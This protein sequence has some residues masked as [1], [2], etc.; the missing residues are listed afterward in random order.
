MKDKKVLQ[1]EGASLKLDQMPHNTLNW[2]LVLEDSQ[3]YCKHHDL[4]DNLNK[5]LTELI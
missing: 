4:R 1:T 3:A 5:K 2:T